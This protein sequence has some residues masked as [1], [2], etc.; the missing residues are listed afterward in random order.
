MGF[1]DFIDS[2]PSVA[3]FGLTSYAC[4]VVPA[5]IPLAAM[6]G[7]MI[8]DPAQIR[9]VGSRHDDLAGKADSAGTELDQAVGKHSGD[10]DASDK[11][12]FLAANVQPYKDALKKTSEMHKG[13]STTMNS[14]AKVH[15]DL[16]LL[17]MGIG[18]LLAACASGVLGLAFVPGAN[19]A[20]ESA[21]TATAETSGTVLRGALSKLVPLLAKA[22]QLL[23]SLKGMLVAAGLGFF[24]MSTALSKPKSGFDS[25][26][27]SAAAIQW[28]GATPPLGQANP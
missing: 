12:A 13:I 5:A 15:Q 1:D 3:G 4:F 23:T 2:A 8:S 28:P 6:Q 9:H 18:T 21:A 16:G 14:L 10:W 11:Q 7:V 25:A 27:A 19:V 22:V 20:A 17:S 24:G 26:T